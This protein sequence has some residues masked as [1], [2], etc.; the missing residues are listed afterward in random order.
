LPS[1][2]VLSAPVSNPAP[3]HRARAK[4]VAEAVELQLTIRLE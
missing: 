4:Y 2:I 1:L 3:S